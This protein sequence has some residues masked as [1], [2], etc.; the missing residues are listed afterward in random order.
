MED[1]SFIYM[2]CSD[3]RTNTVL[4]ADTFPMFYT[5][6][7]G[8]FSE[9]YNDYM[10]EVVSFAMTNG[11]PA[12]STY[13]MFASDNLGDSGY[14]C[15][16]KLSPKDNILSIIPMNAITDAYIQ[17][18]GGGTIMFRVNNCRQPKQVTF[19]FLKPDFS[20]AITGTD[21]NVTSVETK[22]ILTL[23]MTPIR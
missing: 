13:L 9:Q 1:K 23:K 22:W 16:N 8:G 6:D 14:F 17:S 21:V 11:F 10:C 3:D 2:I 20:L 18:D 5:V 19:Y 7:F 12:N 15:K 4:P